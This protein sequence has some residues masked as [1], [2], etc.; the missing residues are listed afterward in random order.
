MPT[1][2]TRPYPL[3]LVATRPSEPAPRTDDELIDAVLAG[4]ER[5]AREFHD[6][7]LPVIERSIH[8]VLRTHPSAHGDLVQI[9]FEQVVE[10][11]F[12]NKFARACSLKT[13]ADRIASRV[14]LHALR[15]R[16]RER[17]TAS[18]DDEPVDLVGATDP[19][20]QVQA[21]VQLRW[22]QAQL[23]AMKPRRAEV[24]LLHDLEGY[25]L[26]EI[27][28]LMGISVTSAQS[29]LVRARRQILREHDRRASRARLF[30]GAKP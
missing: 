25:E 4:D 21:R 20:G 8:R 29:L 27:A 3:T 18:E 2:R 15:E 30:R 11:L 16:Y 28:L 13:W 23:A 9:A 12:R 24:L 10:T 22:L 14:A 6:L 19:E 17:R 5:I 1:A 7:L 26:G